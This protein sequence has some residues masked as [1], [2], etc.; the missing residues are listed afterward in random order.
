VAFILFSLKTNRWLSLGLV[1]RFCVLSIF[2]FASL[3][4]FIHGGLF[5]GLLYAF[6]LFQPADDLC[7]KIRGQG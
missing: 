2:G 7:L 6:L 1:R 4:V 5:V 3:I